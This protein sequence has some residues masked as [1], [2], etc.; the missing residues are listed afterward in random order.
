MRTTRKAFTLIELLVVISIIGILVALL[1]PALSRARESARNTACKNNLAQIGKAVAIFADRDPSGRLCTGAS[2]FRRDGCMDT[3]GWV[4][5]IKNINAA[6]PGEMVCPSNPLRASEKVN[7]LVGQDTNDGKEAAP[8]GRT[9]DGVCGAATYLGTAGG[10]STGIFGN[11][12]GLSEQ[13][14][15][16]VARAIMQQGYFTNYAAGWHFVRSAPKLG[17]FGSGAGIAMPASLTID[18]GMGGTTTKNTSLKGWEGTLGGLTLRIL[19]GAPVVTSNIAL[20]GDGAPGDVSEAV[21]STTVAKTSGDPWGV[22]LQDPEDVTY[23]E[24]GELL[25]EAFNDGPA[26]YDTSGKKVALQSGKAPADMTTQIQCER[27][28]GCPAATGPAGSKTFLQDTR[29]WFAVHGGGKNGTLNVLMADFSV[30]EFAD[31]DGDSFLNPGFP[32]PDGL[33]EAEYD[34]IGYR[35]NAVELPPTEMFNGVFLINVSKVKDLE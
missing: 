35:S 33:T 15:N 20:L 3:W 16:V 11:T 28:G 14:G 1:L 9:S 30:K 10:G 31:T 25:T 26:Y 24:A 13:R 34:G 18:D 2:D 8:A 6:N 21:L 27:E 12:D 22:A 4:A 17:E 5:D 23:L 32:V 29:D 19:E 7:D